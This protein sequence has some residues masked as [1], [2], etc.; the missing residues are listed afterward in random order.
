MASVD[1]GIRHVKMSSTRNRDVDTV[2]ATESPES[3]KS[4]GA[5]VRDH[6]HV[7][8]RAR[9]PESLLVGAR[10]GGVT[11]H[12]LPHPSELPDGHEIVDLP[13]GEAEATELTARNHAV[14]LC[15]RAQRVW[16]E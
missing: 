14:A 5:R 8:D 6:H 3:T 13:L 4:T 15:D 9:Q 12:A 16:T 1:D 11:K 10:R 7:R 2:I